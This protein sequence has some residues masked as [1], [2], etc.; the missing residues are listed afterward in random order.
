MKEMFKYENELLPVPINDLEVVLNRYLECVLPIVDNETYIKTEKLCNDFLGNEGRVLFDK[1]MDWKDTLDRGSWLAPLQVDEFLSVREPV[2]IMGNYA[3]IL[4]P[5]NNNHIKDG[6]ELTAAFIYATIKIYVEIENET[7]KPILMRNR[8]PVSMKPFKDV[9]NSCR[10]PKKG[11]D[12]I[13]AYK[14][15]ADK[16][17]EVCFFHNG[18]YWS[19]EVIDSD[20]NI[21]EYKDIL[22][23]IK[24]IVN[25]NQNNEQKHINSLSVLGSDK[26]SY[27]IGKIVDFDDKNQLGF[28]KLND[29][30]FNISYLEDDILSD[31]EEMHD[32]LYGNGEKSGATNHG[33]SV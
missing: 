31:G 26:A 20:G 30:I 32:T 1:T 24:T 5:D 11:M 33:Q 23:T 14:N 18:R 16:G 25:E 12:E 7:F 3:G 15:N 6:I 22:H 8:I 27:L 21:C 10:V 9:F 2:T 17:R 29:S 13:V 28:D 19:I 4:K